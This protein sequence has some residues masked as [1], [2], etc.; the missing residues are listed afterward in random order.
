MIKVNNVYGAIANPYSPELSESGVWATAPRTA[1]FVFSTLSTTE[2]PKER[3][4]LH[5]HINFLVI[6]PLSAFTITL[7]RS[8]PQTTQD[9]AFQRLCQK[10]NV[11]EHK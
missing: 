6:T 4:A 2:S 7:S 3:L 9:T 11:V 5:A 10:H 1:I 8:R